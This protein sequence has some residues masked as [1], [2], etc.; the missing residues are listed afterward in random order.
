MIYCL[1]L[2][3]CIWFN[4]LSMVIETMG[5]RH[6]KS[7]YSVFIHITTRTM[8]IVLAYVD[9]LLVMGNNLATIMS[10]KERLKQ[11]FN[12]TDLGEFW[13]YLGLEITNTRHRIFM[14]QCKYALDF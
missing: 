14:D 10:M 5:F 3:S 11:R 13:Y 12:I 6:S 8:T 4:T 9:D 1:K 2:A 7:D